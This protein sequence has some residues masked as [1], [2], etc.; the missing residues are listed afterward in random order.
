MRQTKE[1]LLKRL[2]SAKGGHEQLILKKLK[3][4]GWEP[5]EKAPV[6]PKAKKAPIKK[7]AKKKTSKK[8]PAKKKTD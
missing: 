1:I 7:A 3:K 5:M 8:K 2:R 6:K 4:L